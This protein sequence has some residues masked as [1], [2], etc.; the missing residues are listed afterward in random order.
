MTKKGQIRAPAEVFKRGSRRK[1]F[2]EHMQTG[3]SV[4]E[5]D[6]RFHELLDRLDEAEKEQKT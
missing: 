2:A 4:P 6:D 3:H 1:D 5:N